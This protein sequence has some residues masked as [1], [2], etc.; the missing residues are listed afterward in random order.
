MVEQLGSMHVATL[1]IDPFSKGIDESA[2]VIRQ[3]AKRQALFL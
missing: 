1:W 3:P 2:E